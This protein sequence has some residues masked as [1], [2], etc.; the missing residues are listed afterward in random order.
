MTKC[1]RSIQKVPSLTPVRSSPCDSCSLHFADASLQSPFHSPTPAQARE[2][3]SFALSA[4]CSKTRPQQMRTPAINV[5]TVRV[6]DAQQA[7][8]ARRRRGGHDLP[9]LEDGVGVASTQTHLL[10]HGVSAAC[11][12][13]HR[14]SLR[15]EIDELR[16]APPSRHKTS[17][18]RPQPDGRRGG[19]P[20]TTACRG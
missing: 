10:E 2:Q 8:S 14:E 17:G 1:V 18:A 19:W 13:S 4:R 15:L 9:A 11:S 7:Y 3:L 20:P 6:A 5:Q 12:T 16:P